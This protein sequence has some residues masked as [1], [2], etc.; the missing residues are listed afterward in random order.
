MKDIKE[1]A[2]YFFISLIIVSGVLFLVLSIPPEI[3][4]LIISIMLGLFIFIGFI[5]FLCLSNY[6]FKHAK[7]TVFDVFVPPSE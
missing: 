3:G 7:C 4:K 5:F 1:T 6:I 2:L